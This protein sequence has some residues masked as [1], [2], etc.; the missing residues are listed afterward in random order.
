MHALHIFL[1]S[2]LHKGGPGNTIAEKCSLI[3]ANACKTALEQE[4]P[5]SAG[6][7]SYGSTDEPVSDGVQLLA[8]AL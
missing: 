2:A 8:M 7:D 5:G 6:T 1:S 3:P 4:V